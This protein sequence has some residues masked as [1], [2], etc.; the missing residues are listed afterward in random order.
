[1]DEVSRHWSWQP[2]ATLPPRW[3]DPPSTTRGGRYPNAAGL[4][5][6]IQAQIWPDYLA[7]ALLRQGHDGRPAAP[8]RPHS[9]PTGQSPCT[10]ASRHGWRRRR[11][12]PLEQAAP[13]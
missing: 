11:I 4:I 13:A 8:C 9:A 12:T 10:A 3:G 7:A 2:S 1:L 5:R 6:P